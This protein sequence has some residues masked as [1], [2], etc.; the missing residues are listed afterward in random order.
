MPE[1]ICWRCGETSFSGYTHACSDRKDRFTYSYDN[2]KK[3]WE[4]YVRRYK[5]M[6][7]KA[8]DSEHCHFCGRTAKECKDLTDAFIEEH[9]DE[10]TKDSPTEN[11]VERLNFIKGLLLTNQQGGKTSR[12]IEEY[13]ELLRIL[14]DIESASD[15]IVSK[16]DSWDQKKYSA[17]VTCDYPFANGEKNELR[18]L[19]D[20]CASVYS[21]R[22]ELPLGSCNNTLG[23]V[24][25]AV[26]ENYDE[27]TTFIEA[28]L[29]ELKGTLV[30]D[31][32]V[33][34]TIVHQMIVDYHSS[35]CELKTVNIG[36]FDLSGTLAKKDI[37]SIYSHPV[38]H[39]IQFDVNIC[40]ICD[41]FFDRFEGREHYSPRDNRMYPE[42][43]PHE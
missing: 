30:E 15:D 8:N 18:N 28:K 35:P 39:S 43:N 9:F 12:Y 37:N 6:I 33:D 5:G 14:D 42:F 13:R 27:L 29:K 10:F 24:C 23:S 3:L 38:E 25:N 2:E 17:A 4:E 7:P 32:P 34:E 36:S 21:V 40:W 22:E 20:R 26:K 19:L 31:L 1:K 11:L 41:R 16:Y